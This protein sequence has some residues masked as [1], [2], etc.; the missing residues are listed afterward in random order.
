MSCNMFNMPVE[1]NSTM[2]SFRVKSGRKIDTQIGGVY[3]HPQSVISDFNPDEFINDFTLLINKTIKVYLR[4]DVEYD[5][6]YNQLN[7]T[8]NTTKMIDWDYMTKIEK[9]ANVLLKFCG[10]YKKPP[11]C[12]VIEN[13]TPAA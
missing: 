3:I 9:C 5:E 4:I 7:I 6:Y 1:L 13:Y 2:I 12:F 8:V 11:K 10:K